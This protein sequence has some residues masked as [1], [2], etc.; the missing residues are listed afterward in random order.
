MGMHTHDRN[1]EGDFIFGNAYYIAHQT[2][3][4]NAWSNFVR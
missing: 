4:L 3:H 1:D 2:Q